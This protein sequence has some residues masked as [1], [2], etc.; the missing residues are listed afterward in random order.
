MHR[1]AH[2]GVAQKRSPAWQNLLIRGLHVGMSS[3]DRRNLAV[4]K[5]SD[6]DFLA[7]RFAM[8]IDN[9]VRSFLTHLSDGRFD[10]AEW[11][12]QNRLHKCTALHVDHADLAFG[13]F[14]HDRSAAGRASWII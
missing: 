7:R 3:D 9:N 5:M 8:N 12:L 4:K 2:S 1:P 14:E 10:R 6:R 13:C 11:I